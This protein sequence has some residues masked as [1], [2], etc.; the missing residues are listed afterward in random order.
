MT[1]TAEWQ[2][3]I[4]M[5]HGGMGTPGSVVRQMQFQHYYIAETA[6]LIRV[7]RPL[8]NTRLKPRA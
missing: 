1:S 2:P 6:Q 8:E 5:F 7:P 3:A 4:A